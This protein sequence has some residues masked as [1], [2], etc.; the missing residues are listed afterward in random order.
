[1]LLF[2]NVPFHDEKKKE[3]WPSHMTK[4]PLYQQ[5][6]YILFIPMLGVTAGGRA[7]VP[8]PAESAPAKKIQAWLHF[9]I[10]YIIM[11]PVLLYHNDN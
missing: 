1:M 11:N 9:I 2:L 8:S 4:H 7:R 6:I 3:I 10:L 5:K